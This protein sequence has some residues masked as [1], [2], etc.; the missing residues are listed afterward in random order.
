MAIT[1]YTRTYMGETKMR[2]RT[3][4][5]K[6][7]DGNRLR[8]GDRVL[9]LV[10]DE[11]GGPYE[12]VV[13]EISASGHGITIRLARGETAVSTTDVVKLG[14]SRAAKKAAGVVKIDDDNYEV[15]GVKIQRHKRGLWSVWDVARGGTPYHVASK[16]AAIRHAHARLSDRYPDR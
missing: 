15:G 14:T 10:D 5:G 3:T 11:Y 8:L 13:R 16:N 1:G 7:R 2:R 12:G 6:D 4:I 9:Y